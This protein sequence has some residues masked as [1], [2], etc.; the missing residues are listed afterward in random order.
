MKNIKISS[1][2]GPTSHKPQL[3]K[4]ADK[5][6]ERIGKFDVDLIFDLG[7]DVSKVCFVVVK[8]ECISA[9]GSYG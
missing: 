5:G 7:R 3:A 9:P 1:L 2:L 8:V 6:K 4:D